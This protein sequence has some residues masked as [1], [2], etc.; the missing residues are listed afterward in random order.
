MIAARVYWDFGRYSDLWRDW[1]P[2]HRVTFEDCLATV[3][4]VSDSIRWSRILC[5]LTKE[6][7][8]RCPSSARMANAEVYAKLLVRELLTLFFEAR[9]REVV[10]RRA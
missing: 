2:V 6:A 4:Q 9:R 8:R 1:R 10:E 5:E 7:W 3:R